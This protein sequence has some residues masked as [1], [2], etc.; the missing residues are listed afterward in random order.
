MASTSS[1]YN[2][3]IS[4][5]S[6]KLLSAAN[7]RAGQIAPLVESGTPLAKLKPELASE[8]GL[9]DVQVVATCSHDTGAAVA[10]VPAEGEDWAY[11]SSG[12]WSLIGVELDEP[13]ISDRSREL[14]YTH[15]IGHGNTI[16]FLRNIIG[17]WMQLRPSCRSTFRS[18]LALI[19]R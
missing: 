15:E 14:N 3:R 9:G 4:D 10:A 7:V 16:R 6:E 1:M 8:S 12:T 5:W 17:L 2:P 18:A 13:Q 11:L 19:V